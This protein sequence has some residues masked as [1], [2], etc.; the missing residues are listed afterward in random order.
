M[1]NTISENFL[2]IN[3]Q[4]KDSQKLE[5]NG[6]DHFARAEQVLTDVPE[7]AA[8]T[9]TQRGISEFSNI[10]KHN[11]IGKFKSSERSL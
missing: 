1:K 8:F 6:A 2:G 3:A 11:H 7:N 4:A 9:D 10:I 5:G